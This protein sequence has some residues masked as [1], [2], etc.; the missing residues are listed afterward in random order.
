MEKMENGEID[1][2][3][4][5]WAVRIRK[6]LIVVVTL[7]C[8]VVGGGVMNFRSSVKYRSDLAV[9]LGKKAVFNELFPEQHSLEYTEKPAGL[10]KSISAKYGT[11]NNDSS[12]YHIDAKFL[13]ASSILSIIVTGPDRGTE[14]V[15]NEIVKRLIVDYNRI[16]DVSLARYKD[17]MTRFE[18]DVKVAQDNVAAANRKLEKIKGLD[19]AVLDRVIVEWEEGVATE[20]IYLM[21]PLIQGVASLGTRIA[22]KEIL[23]KK[24]ESRLGSTQDKLIACQTFLRNFNGYKTKMIGEVKNS[25]I[26]PKRVRSALMCGVIGLILSLFLVFVLECIKARSEKR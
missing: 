13:N 22:D 15:L 16:E 3:N 26:E 8:L 7:V 24:E 4:I 5:V 14:K 19:K 18:A 20:D 11:G 17:A 23:L 9:R 10:E 1:L 2:K 21:G 6:K 25:V 12:R